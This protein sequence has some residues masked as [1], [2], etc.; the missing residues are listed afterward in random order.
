M[1]AVAVH[2][3]RHLTPMISSCDTRRHMLSR[4]RQNGTVTPIDD[5]ST[6]RWQWTTQVM[7]QRHRWP[8]RWQ[9]CPPWSCCR[10][11]RSCRRCRWQCVH[12]LS[13]LT[14][15]R[16]ATAS[17]SSIDQSRH[18]CSLQQETRH[19][20]SCIIVTWW[21]DS[22]GIQAWSLMTNW[23]S[24]V[25]WHCW[26]GHLACKYYPRNDLLCVEWDVKSYT[27]THLQTKKVGLTYFTGKNTSRKSGPEQAFSS[28]LSFAARGILVLFA[29]EYFRYVSIMWN[30]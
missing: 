8:P 5:V 9:W 17:H 23:F 7:L 10:L 11:M 22:N 16:S 15:D 20:Q 19:L 14:A 21:S 2:S 29:S 30:L 12:P 18:S 24:S 1:Q 4:C 26:F 13:P 25:L 3:R 6:C 28:Q 27:L